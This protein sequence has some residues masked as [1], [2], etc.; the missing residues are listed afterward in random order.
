MLSGISLLSLLFM[1]KFPTFDLFFF[2]NFQPYF[3]PAFSQEGS[4]K[5]AFGSSVFDLYCILNLFAVK[6]ICR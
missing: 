3:S 2:Q 1:N 6:M 5:S 4:W